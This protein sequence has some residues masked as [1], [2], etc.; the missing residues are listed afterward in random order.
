MRKTKKGR[1]IL[2]IGP[3]EVGKTA[4]FT[5]IITDKNLETVTSVSPNQAEYT[6]D[7]KPSLIL[8]DLPGH[9][10]VRIQFWDSNKVG[11]RGIVCVV[12]AAGGNKAIREAAEVLY[13]VLT[14]PVVSSVGPNILIFCNKQDLPTAKGTKVIRTQLEREL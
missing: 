12:D 2:F 5:K 11:A 1:T 9:E 3:P 13:T 7:N 8:K 14:D 6:P 10:R 4:I